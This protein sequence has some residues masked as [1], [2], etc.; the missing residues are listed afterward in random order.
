MIDVMIGGISCFSSFWKNNIAYSE[1]KE[2]EREREGE[3][4]RKKM[5]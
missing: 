3:K 2:I 5:L 1:R 4:S